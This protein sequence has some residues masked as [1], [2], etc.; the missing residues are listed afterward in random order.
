[1]CLP[2]HIGELRIARAGTLMPC[3]RPGTLLAQL[4]EHAAIHTPYTTPHVAC[5]AIAFARTWAPA[6]LQVHCGMVCVYAA[7][8]AQQLSCS[9]T[10][11]SC[12]GCVAEVCLTFERRPQ[13]CRR[14]A[15]HP[16]HARVMHAR[17]L[18]ETVHVALLLATG[19]CVLAYLTLAL[20]SAPPLNCCHDHIIVMTTPYVAGCCTMWGQTPDASVRVGKSSEF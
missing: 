16:L 17:L 8:S 20:R 2:P 18:I 3:I 5:C 10:G 9:S 13:R 11:A 7:A 14:V 19:A 6:S 15:Q 12:H 4:L 1:M